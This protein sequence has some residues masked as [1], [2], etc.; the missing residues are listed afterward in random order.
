MGEA[1]VHFKHNSQLCVIGKRARG[2]PPLFCG[3]GPDH[4]AFGSSHQ[5]ALG[6]GPVALSQAHAM[7]HL[8]KLVHLD[9][10]VSHG[11]TSGKYFAGILPDGWIKPEMLFDL[12]NTIPMIDGPIK[13]TTNWPH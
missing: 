13:V 3:N 5:L 8:T 10:P 1:A 9:P 6:D 4:G 2:K 11:N 7:D 12:D